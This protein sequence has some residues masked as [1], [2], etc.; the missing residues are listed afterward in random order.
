MT[1]LIQSVTVVDGRNSKSVLVGGVD[2]RRVDIQDNKARVIWAPRTSKG[3][4]IDVPKQVTLLTDPNTVTT[5][6][7][8]S[9][10][11]RQLALAE[12]LVVRLLSSPG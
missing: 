3:Q 4:P 12:A 8:E 2:A 6:A 1:P 11:Q 9:D 7:A 5:I 10:V